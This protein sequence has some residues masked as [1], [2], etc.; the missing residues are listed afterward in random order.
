MT[1]LS[2]TFWCAPSCY[3]TVRLKFMPWVEVGKSPTHFPYLIPMWL[4]LMSSNFAS[5][6][7]VSISTSRICLLLQQKGSAQPCPASTGVQMRG[8]VMGVGEQNFCVWRVWGLCLSEW[9]IN[10]QT[11]RGQ[12]RFAGVCR[13]KSELHMRSQAPFI[14]DI[15]HQQ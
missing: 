10:K 15:K 14:P 2:L 1:S 3:Y 6:K 5:P 13:V 8:E 11:E 9:A 4:L 12:E 7:S